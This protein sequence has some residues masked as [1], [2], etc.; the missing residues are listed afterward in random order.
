VNL[1]CSN[2]IIE[3]PKYKKEDNLVLKIPEAE[4]VEKETIAIPSDDE[5]VIESPKALSKFE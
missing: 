2:K 4:I 3:S 1:E 5:K